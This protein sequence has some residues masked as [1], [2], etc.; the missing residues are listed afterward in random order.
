MC[1]DG[2]QRSQWGGGGVAVSPPSA[3]QSKSNYKKAFPRLIFAL[4]FV[5]FRRKSPILGENLFLPKNRSNFW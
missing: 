1:G 2:Q 4:S 5:E 3:C